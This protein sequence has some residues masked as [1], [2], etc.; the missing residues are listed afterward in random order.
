[1]TENN[2]R[3]I[4]FWQLY[5]AIPELKAKRSA[6]HRLPLTRKAIDIALKAKPKGEGNLWG[7]D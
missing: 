6:L 7:P 1:M 2:V 4:F 5:Q 3:R